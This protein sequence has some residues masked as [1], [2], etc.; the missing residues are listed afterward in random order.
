MLGGGEGV[1]V[2]VGV[3]ETGGAPV[4][5]VVGASVG[6]GVASLVGDGTVG[7]G[8]VGD[9]VADG[10]TSAGAPPGWNHR[11]CRHCPRDGLVNRYGVPPPRPTTSMTVLSPLSCEKSYS[12]TT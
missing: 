11:G 6:E 3:G 8:T 9:A 5:V 7:D 1:G 2:A 10:V 4:G 12:W